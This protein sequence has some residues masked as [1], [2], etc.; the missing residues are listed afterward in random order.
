MLSLIYSDHELKVEFKKDWDTRMKRSLI[1]MLFLHY[2]IKGKYREQGKKWNESYFIEKKALRE[3]AALKQIYGKDLTLEDLRKEIANIDARTDIFN[4]LETILA[5]YFYLSY[6]TNGTSIDFMHETFKEY[7]L[8]EFYIESLLENKIDRLNVRTPSRQTIEFLGR[9]IELLNAKD[10]DILNKFI[11]WNETSQI[12]LLNSF[13]YDKGL[14]NAKRQLV[15]SALSSINNEHIVFLDVN[16]NMHEA[17]WREADVTMNDYKNLWM[18]RWISLY[19]LNMLA[20]EMHSENIHKE[21]LR[22]LIVG[23]SLSAPEYIKTLKHANLSAANL[24]DANLSCA[25]LS[26]AN[27]SCA[28]LPCA[29]LSCANLSHARLAEANLSAAN[30]SAANLSRA[31]A[32]GAN[33]SAANL[34]AANLS[35]A[36]MSGAKFLYSM[37]IGCRKYDELICTDADLD[38]AIIDRED[39]GYYLKCNAA[40]NVPPSMTSRKSLEVALT[41]RK[42]DDST[43]KELLGLT[44]L[45]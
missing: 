44:S 45:S 10:K 38:K 34:S 5:S 3:V 32:D 6:K 26:N 1:Y 27:L 14:E 29:N 36:N 35:A 11:E 41:Y 7:L 40:K 8:A 15:Y 43:V 28:N 17:I 24:T 18:H 21:K 23:S 20:P 9:L 25:D 13:N 2:V 12:S 19:V 31:I 4:K 33:L 39:L 22:N 42:I 16:A 37:I 30:L